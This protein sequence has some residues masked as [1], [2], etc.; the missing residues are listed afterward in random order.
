MLRIDGQTV[1]L[2]P[3]DADYRSAPGE[4]IPPDTQIPDMYLQFPSRVVP[5]Q[6]LNGMPAG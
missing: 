6:H 2:M 3:W 5:P 1:A 4:G